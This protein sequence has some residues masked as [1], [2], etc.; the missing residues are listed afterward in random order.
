M[1]LP[2]NFPGIFRWIFTGVFPLIGTSTTS[3]LAQKAI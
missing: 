3:D 1:N 2:I